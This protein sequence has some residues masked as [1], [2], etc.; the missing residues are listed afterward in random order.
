MNDSLLI[1]ANVLDHKS[2]E[3]A[4][5]RIQRA[6][7]IYMHGYV[8]ALYILARCLIEKGTDLRHLGMKA[9]V[10]ESEKLYQFQKQTMEQA[11]G[12]PIVEH[13]GSLEFGMLAQRDPQG[14]MRIHEDRCIVERLSGGEAVI[15]SLHAKAYP[16]LRY[17]VGDLLELDD[18]VTDGLPYASIKSLT[19]RVADLVPLPRGGYIH[20]FIL[21]YP[22]E[23]F[24]KYILRF[25][26]HQTRID[27]FVIRWVL[28]APVP[29]EV[30]QKIVQAFH[31]AAGEDVAVEFQEVDSLPNT[32]S[33]KFRWVIS[34]VSDV[35]RQVL[36][37][38]SQMA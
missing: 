10:T 14:V 15:T 27:Q 29:E 16:F 21:H 9:V 35:A 8:S 22:F 28:A 34:D 30:R 36:A 25:Q 19:G 26:I 12:C 31:A 24:M 37:E 2:A 6:R 20:G 33:G 23:R 7:P 13:Y 3:D 38:E 18:H 11:F 17:K 32:I 4:L 1:N 5:D